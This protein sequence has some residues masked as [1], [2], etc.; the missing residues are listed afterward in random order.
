MAQREK[1]CLINAI[2]HRHRS[3][4]R[5]TTTHTAVVDAVASLESDRITNTLLSLAGGTTILR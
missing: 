4:S 1:A 5:H 2:D 3:P